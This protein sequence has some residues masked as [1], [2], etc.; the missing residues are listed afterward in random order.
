M[1]TKHSKQREFLRF[2]AV[3]YGDEDVPEDALP[4]EKRFTRESLIT[5]HNEAE[6]VFEEYIL[7]VAASHG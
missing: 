5:T 4:P 6:G 7:G 1:N 3:L 2:P